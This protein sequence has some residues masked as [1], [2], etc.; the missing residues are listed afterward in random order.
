MR[1][2]RGHRGPENKND[3][4]EF[5][6]LDGDGR[7]ERKKDSVQEND[8]VREWED[9]P[10]SIQPWK[11]VGIF[12][13]LAIVAAVV[14]LGLWIFT[15]RESG[16]KP[17]AGE[18]GLSE[19]AA[20]M[21]EEAMEPSNGTAV[22]IE[23]A[24]PQAGPQGPDAETSDPEGSGPKDPNAESSAPEP[25][26]QQDPKPSSA[27]G[28]ES[29]NPAAEAGKPED[30]P[31]ASEPQN[32]DAAMSFDA[33]RESVTP[34]DV[35]NLRSVPSAAEESSIVAQ[36]ENGEVLSR[37]GINPDTGWSKIDYDGRTLYA[38][39]QYL[40]T[41]LSYQTPVAP[42]DPNR[43]NTL[44]GRVIIFNDCDDQVTP[45]EYVNLRTEPSTTEG[46]A[47]V[48]CQAGNGEQLHRTGVSPDSGWSRVEYNGQVLYVVT[49]LVKAVQ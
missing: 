37:T 46:D 14:A 6:D 3:G 13:V 24:A 40:T 48:S 19:A 38:V 45:K 15:H 8:R 42:A 1:N 9:D 39:T 21:S 43:V 41:D 36:A 16:R 31:A 34:K 35:V 18:A 49:S 10:E 17:G 11:M 12:A 5:L 33:V 2:D 47:T 32:G 29:E 28:G 26:P 25:S 23:S 7:G 44:S 4:I 20:E 27:P 30:S 22:P